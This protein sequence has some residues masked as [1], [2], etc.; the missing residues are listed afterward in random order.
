MTE[1]TTSPEDR[2]QGRGDRD[3]HAPRAADPATRRLL[4]GGG[5]THRAGVPGRQP[6]RPGGI[7]HLL[8]RAVD[9][10]RAAG[11]RSAWSIWPARRPSEVVGQPRRGRARPGQRRSGDRNREPAAEPRHGRAAG[12]SASPLAFWSATS[13][14]G[15]FMR[16]SNTIYDVPEGRPIWKTVPIQLAITAVVMVLL[17]GVARSRSCSPAGWPGGGPASGIGSARSRVWDIAK[18]PVLVRGRRLHVRAALLGRAQRA[19]GRFRWIT[20]GSVLAV[21]VWVVASAGFAFYIAKFDSYNKTYG[22]WAE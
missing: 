15:A 3:S 10:P 21:V 13:Y 6:Q 7:A 20:P 18:W 22:A 5:Q 9:L 16:A 1:R 14:I 12:L 19:P 8:Q 2:A 4:V 17:R 11:A